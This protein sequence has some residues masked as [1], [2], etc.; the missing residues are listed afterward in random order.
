MGGCVPVA[1]QFWFSSGDECGAGDTVS[2]IN[3]WLG[4]L[5]SLTQ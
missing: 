4:K 3:I 5:L 1:G 2:K